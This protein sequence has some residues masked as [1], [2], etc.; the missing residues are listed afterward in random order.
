M[1]RFWVGAGE[2][3]FFDIDRPGLSSLDSVLRVFNSAGSE[4]ARNDDGAAPG[5]TLGRESYLEHTFPTGGAYFLGVSAFP[6]DTYNA[7][8]GAGD[9]TGFFAGA[10][11]IATGWAADPDDQ[12]SE[13]SVNAVPGTKT[14]H[15]IESATDADLFRFSAVAGDR[16]AFDLDRPADSLNILDSVIRIFNAAGTELARNDDA[17]TP[18]E[19]LSIESF[20]VFDVPTT[21]SYAI[22]VSAF[23]N[24]NYNPTTGAGDGA[25]GSTG[26]YTLT[27]TII[28]P[29]DQ[30]SEA[31]PISVGTPVSGSA[32]RGS[33]VDM[34]RL[35]VTAGQ[36]ITFDIDRPAGG[37]LDSYLRIFNTAGTEIAANDDGP[38]PD[39]GATQEAY[40]V[41]QFATAGTF[42]VGV[43]AFSNTGYSPTAGTGDRNGS[44]GDYTLRLTPDTAFNIV[45]DFGTTTPTFTQRLAFQV[46][47]ARWSQVITGDLPG[48]GTIDDL[49][50]T[51]RIEPIDG[52][53]G[54]VGSANFTSLRTGSNLPF[55]GRMRFDSADVANQEA[56]GSLFNL[57]LHE[58]GH[59]LGIGS[60]WNNLGLI[61][62]AGTINPTYTGA[63]AVRE[64]N[65]LFGNTGNVPVENTG[66]PGTRDVHIRESVFQTELMTGFWAPAPTR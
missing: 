23:G 24:T 36:R 38:N 3:V 31:R 34:Y 29:D 62:G 43:S 1:F 48:V 33:D 37:T 10:F 65:T 25:G 8:S 42:F 45:V 60:L 2:R 40:L 28:D 4:I 50:I 61:R 16:I 14:G 44:A 58:M 64:Y 26:A 56:S 51:A 18:D 55:T 49:L 7:V 9:A 12:I 57:V 54:I 35:T 52:T 11:T 17:I 6:N 27:T 53:G 66:N 13:A 21:G 30:I 46:A 19:P 32:S 59:V 15:R 63:N 20:L 22:G 41:H 39:E 5:E 47:A